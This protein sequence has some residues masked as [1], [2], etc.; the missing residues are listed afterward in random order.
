MSFY[1]YYLSLCK[2][3]KFHCEI[4]QAECSG[5]TKCPEGQVWSTSTECSKTCE[6]LHLPC[7][8]MYSLA[9]CRCPNNTVWDSQKNKCVLPT[10]CPCHYNGR[11]YQ[12]G[13]SYPWDCNN[14]YVA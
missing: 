6:T 11:T 8:I 2:D 4:D 14:W 1:C 3:G 13:E 10:E 9:G 5:T 7:L 12:V